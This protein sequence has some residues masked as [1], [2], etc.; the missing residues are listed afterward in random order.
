MEIF[1]HIEGTEK[2]LH[3]NFDPI[4]GTKNLLRFL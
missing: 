4:E 1:H 2:R 3:G